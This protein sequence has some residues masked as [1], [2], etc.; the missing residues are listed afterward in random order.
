[1]PTPVEQW[2]E[3]CAQLTHPKNIHWCDGSEA[4]YQHM[5]HDMLETGTLH[6]AQSERVPRLLSAPERSHRR[7]T[8]RAPHL[9]MHGGAPG[10]R[11]QQQLDGPG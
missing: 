11:T 8:D 7:G 1:M 4:E 10:C 5:I 6:R 3:E 2:V 9:C